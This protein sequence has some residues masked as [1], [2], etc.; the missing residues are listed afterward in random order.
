MPSRRAGQWRYVLHWLPVPSSCKNPYIAPLWLISTSLPSREAHIHTNPQFN[1]S[2]SYQMGLWRAQCVM[3]PTSKPS[4]RGEMP[5]CVSSESTKRARASGV[6]G[7]Q[8]STRW[9]NWMNSPANKRVKNA[10][11]SEVGRRKRYLNLLDIVSTVQ[12]SPNVF[13]GDVQKQACASDGEGI[14]PKIN[15]HSAASVRQIL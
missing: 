7:E 1:S 6:G 5:Q 9:V 8:G 4:R 2:S 11:I 15:Q 12:Q 10:V 14:H 13:S 3:L